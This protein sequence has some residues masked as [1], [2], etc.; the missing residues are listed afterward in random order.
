MADNEETSAV[1]A[2]SG[3]TRSGRD[4]SAFRGYGA[5]ENTGILRVGQNQNF[6]N[7]E[8]PTGEVAVTSVVDVR[9][10]APENRERRVVVT[11][12]GELSDQN[13]LL[14]QNFGILGG[15]RKSEF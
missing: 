11:Q 13:V 8:V 10:E 2:G 14:C 15:G 9:R 3:K 1:G 4:F 6:G 7:F 12:S 5:P